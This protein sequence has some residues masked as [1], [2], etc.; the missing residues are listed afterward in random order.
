MQYYENN[1][2]KQLTLIIYLTL[3]ISTRTYNINNQKYLTSTI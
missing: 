1:L 3:H 2:I